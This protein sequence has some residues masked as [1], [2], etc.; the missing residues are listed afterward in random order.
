MSAIAMSPAHLA[1]MHRARQAAIA[2]AKREQLRSAISETAHLHC[3]C[4][5]N[6]RT[7]RADLDA[8]G[9][10]CTMPAYCC[11][12]LDAVRRRVGA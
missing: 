9:G 6:K 2:R 1:K 12:R 11:P 7:T 4:G 10:G 3:R 8:L 5:L